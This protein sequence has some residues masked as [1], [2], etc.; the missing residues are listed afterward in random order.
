MFRS[1]PGAGWA[2]IVSKAKAD[3]EMK[4]T[5]IAAKEVLKKKHHLDSKAWVDEDVDDVTEHTMILRKE[6][7]FL[8]IDDFEKHFKT[9]IG[10]DIATTQ[11]TLQDGS[12]KRGVTMADPACPWHRLILESKKG[13][14]L[15]KKVG[16]ADE[17]LRPE[18]NT[19]LLE[20]LLGKQQQQKGRSLAPK[21]EAELRQTVEARMQKETSEREMT[22]AEEAVP[23]APLASTPERRAGCDK[24]MASP[25]QFTTMSRVS[26][27]SGILAVAAADGTQSQ[28]RRKGAGKGKPKDGSSA[29]SK[30][31]KPLTGSPS[32]LRRF[33]PPKHKG[34]GDDLEVEGG[35]NDPSEAASQCSL[36][37]SKTAKT[38]TSRLLSKG[39]HLEVQAAKYGEDQLSVEDALA[40]CS[41]KTPK[42]QARRILNAMFREQGE[43]AYSTEEYL[44]LAAQK[45]LVES[46]EILKAKLFS[47]SPAEAK[48]QLRPVMGAISV[49]QIP[50]SFK[51]QLLNFHVKNMSF[52]HL[53]EIQ[54]WLEAVRPVA[55]PSQDKPL[56]FDWQSPKA[57]A[58]DGLDDVKKSKCF[59][60]LVLNHSV[61]RV[62]H[63]GPQG[64]TAL[65][66]MA[67]V[68]TAALTELLDHGIGR[69][70]LKKCCEEVLILAKAVTALCGG[71]G[72][73]ECLDEAYQ[74]FD[75]FRHKVSEIPHWQQAE[76]KLREY[77]VA[78]QTLQPELLQLEEKL[79]TKYI[80]AEE[81]VKVAKRLPVFDEGLRT[82]ATL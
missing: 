61:L 62:L 79:A 13:L 16:V 50:A 38:T 1:Y 30:P 21:T 37:T 19:A 58:I 31:A 75:V 15:K 68:L 5:L 6:M 56:V 80:P 41:M 28:Q 59:R 43:A 8:F 29:K 74:A 65:Q 82:G 42:Y 47:W 36:R 51:E 57:S 27:T 64:A 45:K 3:K 49:S 14:L 77:A 67:D 26:V 69:L 18:Q 25:D 7:W 78:M 17:M 2:E 52:S 48:K 70:V 40:G 72:G 35:V 24:E 32:K 71:S 76:R 34:Q 46:C 11:V 22:A 44:K 81:L 55:P 12:V 20:F 10:P 9:K 39:Q 60:K 66:S 54:A 63:K 33:A 23:A 53:D 73:V 4:D